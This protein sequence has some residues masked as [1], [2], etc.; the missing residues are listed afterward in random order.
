MVF[1]PSV[2][3]RSE[4]T[5]SRPRTSSHSSRLPTAACGLVS[6]PAVRLFS[7]TDAATVMAREGLPA[8]TVN[9]FALD[10]EGAIWAGTTHGLFRFTNSRWEKIGKERGFFAEQAG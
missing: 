9:R 2:I 3:N 10:R 5:R 6:E 7:R 4:A 1:A 8:S